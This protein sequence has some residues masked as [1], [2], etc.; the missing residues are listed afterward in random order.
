MFRKNAKAPT[1]VSSS[2]EIENMHAGSFNLLLSAINP[3]DTIVVNI[4]KSDIKN[5][6]RI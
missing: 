6:N 3:F 1:R 5:L 2:V 4:A